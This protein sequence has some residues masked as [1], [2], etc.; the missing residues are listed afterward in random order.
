MMMLQKKAV[1][2]DL[3]TVICVLLYDNVH[4][5]MPTEQSSQGG[6]FSMCGPYI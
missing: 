2:F 3:G 4:V 5:S 1:E 6:L